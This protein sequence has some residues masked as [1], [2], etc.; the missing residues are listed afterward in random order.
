MHR[1]PKLALLASLPLL[2]AGCSP[3]E[4]QDDA[5]RGMEA[6]MKVLGAGTPAAL[7][8]AKDQ[9]PDDF[10]AF[11][12]DIMGSVSVDADVDCPDGGKMKLEGSAT[13]DTDLG[14]LDGWD[15][16]AT[17]AMEFDLSV[18]FR[19]CKVDGVKINGDLDYSLDIDADS[20]TGSATLDWAY[21]GEV[22]FS[23]EVKGSCEVDMHASASTGNAF[24]DLEVRA[25]A[26]TM[27]GFEAG[28]V[29]GY[30]DLSFGG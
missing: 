10:R 7:T 26:G 25:Y 22:R 15:A 11:G 20:T 21:T 18:D 4:G 9:R 6:M 1:L 8:A 14:N 24:S 16:F 12:L 23:G 5:G 3:L 2:A 30:A 13:L 17:F 28:E 19:R 29:A 27:C